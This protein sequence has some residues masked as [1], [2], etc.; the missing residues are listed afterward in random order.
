M[1]KIRYPFELHGQISVIFKNDIEPVFINTCNN[2]SADILIDDF[3][4]KSFNYDSES[5]TLNISLQKAINA[6]SNISEK[7]INGIELENNIIKLDLTYCLYNAVIISSHISYPLD[8]SSFIK[9]ISVSKSL[10]LNLK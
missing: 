3:V 10:T 4:V 7:L 1:K 8:N 5:R 6:V 9:A 2:N